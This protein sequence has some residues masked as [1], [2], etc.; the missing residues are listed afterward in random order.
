MYPQ[1]CAGGFPTVL[2]LD[3]DDDFV[4]MA[5]VGMSRL[6]Y[7]VTAFT[8]PEEAQ[9]AFLAS[10]H[11]FQVVISDVYMENLSGFDLAKSIRTVC[12]STRIV[13]ISGLVEK[14]NEAEIDGLNIECILTKPVTPK[15]LARTLGCQ[16]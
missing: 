11:S 6:G 9:A 13:L 10:P 3:D 2:L 8:D 12:S 16:V 5:A 14:V 1:G 7:S 4:E 15:G